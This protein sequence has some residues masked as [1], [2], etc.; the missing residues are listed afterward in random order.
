MQLWKHLIVAQLSEPR[1]GKSMPDSRKLTRR[2]VLQVGSGTAA[3]LAMSHLLS[4]VAVAEPEHR[5][6]RDSGAF[7]DHPVTLEEARQR[8]RELG[9]VGDER[10]TAALVT[11]KKTT[12]AIRNSLRGPRFRVYNMGEPMFPGVPAFATIP[13]RKFD[14]VITMYGPLGT[15]LLTVLEERFPS[16]TFQIGTQVDQL[17]HIGIDDVYYGDFPE[18]EIVKFFEIQD[19]IAR[20]ERARQDSDTGN[21][22]PNSILGGTSRLGLEHLGPVVT[23]GV[24]LDVL[25]QKQATGQT[26]ALSADGETL[27]PTYRI[28]IEDIEGAMDF[29][30]IRRIERGDLVLFRTGWSK[31]WE[32]PSRWHEYL[33]SEPGIWLAESRYLAQFRPVIVASDTW[34]LEVVPAPRE[35][36]AFEVHQVLITQEGIR[37]GEAFVSEELAADGV[38]E[39]VFFDTPHRALGATAANNLVAAIGTP[40]RRPGRGRSN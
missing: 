24:L 12:R 2:Q 26:D 39:F 15:N 25:G 18:S 33:E 34:G 27:A 10:G 37:I 14:Y 16:M 28:T 9:V 22:G 11:S 36:S 23:R 5:P 35:G 13:P 40:R 1:A 7:D 6:S 20:W 29:G 38:Y 8:W 31:L 19:P 17:N 3:G 4:D 21:Y 32:D 30:G